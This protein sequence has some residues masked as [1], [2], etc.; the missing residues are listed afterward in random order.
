MK[1]QIEKNMSTIYTSV[2]SILENSHKR[3]IQNI[4]FEMIQAYWKIGE[5]IIE[6]EQQGKARAEHGTFLIKELSNKLS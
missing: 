4:N 6:E 5:I 2:H 3:V 1:L